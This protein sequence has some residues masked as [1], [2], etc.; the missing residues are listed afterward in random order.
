VTFSRSSDSPALAR[1]DYIGHFSHTSLQPV[2]AFVQRPTLHEKIREELQDGAGDGSAAHYGTKT[3]VVWGLGG[4]G[5]TQLALNY[6]QRH[7][8]E[9]KA[10]FWIEAGRKE[11]IERDF[12][13][14]YQLLFDV[15]VPTGQEMI[16]IDD[17]VWAVKSWFSERRDRWLF[18]FNG[19]DTIDNKDASDYI[20]LK[21]FIPDSSYL[22]II[23]TT[24][25][26]TAKDMSPLEG[27]EVGEMDE[28]QAM[29]LFFRLSTL[30]D[31]LQGIEDEV[32]PIVKEL[33]YLALAIT[34]AGTYVAQ[35]P[36]LI[37]NI[38]QYLPDFRQR[39]RELLN[40]KPRDLVDQYSDSVLT[41]W[42]S[43]FRAMADQCSGAS[44][45]LTLLAFLN[46]EDIFLGL[47]N[48][49]LLTSNVEL[50]VQSEEQETTW[51]S[52][53]APGKKLDIYTIEECFRVLKAYS[54][55]Q[56][57]GDQDSYSMH[58][59]V[60]AWGHDR[61][62][63][64]EQHDFSSMVLQL[65]AEAISNCGK[66]PQDKLRLV[67][68]LMANFATVV[69]ASYGQTSSTGITLDNLEKTG[70]FVSSVGKWSE[71]YTIQKFLVDKSGELLGEEHSD[72]L[73][74]MSNLA[75]TLGD[76]GQW[77]E[78]AKMRKE[79][80]EKMRRILGEE[81]L[82]TITAMNNL[83][84]TLRDQGQLDEAAKMQKEVL[85]K[86]RRILGEEHSDTLSAM[87]NLA[88]TLRDQGKLN[89]AAKM[90]KEVLEK[91]RRIFGEEHPDTIS[92]MNNLAA[93]LGDQGQL[94]EAAKMQKEVLEKRRRILG[95]EHSDTLSAMS[96]LA[97]ALRDQGQL[98]EA[99]RMQKEV[100]EK[101]KRI[102]GEEHPDTLS[103]MNN[104]ANT[105]GD[106]GQLDE[107]AKMQK[108]VLEKRRRIF[109]EEHPDTII[110]MNN[111]AITLGDQGQLDEAAKMRK[112]V[113]EKMR[114]ILGEEHPDTI[115]AMNN[116]AA[117]LGDQGQLDEAAKLMKEVL[118]KR[119]RILGEEHPKTKSAKTN[120][121]RLAGM[122]AS[123][124]HIPTTQT[125]VK[126]GI[127][128]RLKRRFIK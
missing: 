116:L 48:V 49:N 102:L 33:G 38:R 50:T 45:L 121:V 104:L 5:K 58:K 122:E 110:A 53:I 56:W 100:L 10:T 128:V 101:R 24:R 69:N 107:A 62:C 115:S 46:S 99:A 111:L 123:P 28:S 75:I 14:I 78:A 54:F 87:N 82:D 52:R 60:H 109:G 59:L 27:V 68:H 120:L 26:R 76:Q 51:R 88:N 55:V 89:E 44:E 36:R 47:F 15:H 98:E 105:L 70:T 97:I 67:P 124:R 85:E 80:L 16:K 29:E 17:V 40:Q 37:S 92:A 108:E 7:R 117:T 12:M 113:L 30:N 127:L 9:Y 71:A 73:S 125:Q 74:A 11:S 64:E 91:R 34:L 66:E 2:K 118:E 84:A 81:H 6:L 35:T 57:K 3:V 1:A 63:E 42:E 77:D 8:N 43:S 119:R 86:R 106:Q 112:E 41:T 83:A 22:H 4:T 94:D 72:T 114:R 103:A 20:D 61:L 93:T 90:M 25:S 126:R 32:K 95:E 21:H 19:A 39:R 31:R 18:V 79:V 13:H 96:N 23:V 65:L